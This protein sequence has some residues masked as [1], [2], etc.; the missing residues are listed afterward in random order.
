[1]DTTNSKIKIEWE[2]PIIKDV[3]RPLMAQPYKTSTLL[4]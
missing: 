1:M 3:T 4:I 2:P